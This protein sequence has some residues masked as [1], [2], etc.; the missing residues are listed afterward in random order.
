[1]L[2]C[3]LPCGHHSPL[4]LFFSLPLDPLLFVQNKNLGC[5]WV[6]WV[7]LGRWCCFMLQWRIFPNEW[8]SPKVH[9]MLST[10]SISTKWKMWLPVPSVLLLCGCIVPGMLDVVVVILSL[11]HKRK[12]WRK[13][14]VGAGYLS[15][16]S[17]VGRPTTTHLII[18]PNLSSSRREITSQLG[19]G[20]ARRQEG[21]GME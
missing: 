4:L 14:G 7:L 3:P 2:F 15:I 17:I 19:G 20:K 18:V 21:I 11:L 16:Y 10:P 13:E 12:G 8:A 9:V 1:M 6:G 5:A